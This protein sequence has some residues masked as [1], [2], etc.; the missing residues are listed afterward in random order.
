[1]YQLKESEE[2]CFGYIAQDILRVGNTKL[3]RIVNVIKKDGIEEQIEE[4]GFINPKDHIFNVAYTDTI[5]LLHNVIKQLLQR[6][7]V[8]EQKLGV[9]P[10]T[11]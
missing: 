6:I 1:M 11:D 8:L 3:N 2:E 5:P 7:E 9:D 10:A 4:D